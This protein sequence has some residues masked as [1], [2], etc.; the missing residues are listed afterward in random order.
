MN[1][2][3]TLPRGSRPARRRYRIA[4]AAAVVLLAGTAVPATAYAAEP[5]ADCA[6]PSV[7]LYQWTGDAWRRTGQ[8]HQF[9]TGW[10]ELTISWGATRILNTRIDDVVYVRHTDGVVGCFGPGADA[11]GEIAPIAAIRISSSPVCRVG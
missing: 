11:G 9:T 2:A 4:A 3:R 6:Y 1:L 7:C 5:A 10:Q 8:F